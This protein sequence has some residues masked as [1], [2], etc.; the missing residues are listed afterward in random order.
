MK[1]KAI[2]VQDLMDGFKKIDNVL[3]KRSQKLRVR[4]LGG[5]SMLLLGLR[6]R[7]TVD[8]DIAATDDS[9]EFQKLCNKLNIPV[10]IIT[11]ATT[12]DLNHCDMVGVFHGKMLTVDSVTPRDLIKLKLERFYKQDPED[13]YAIIE[14]KSISFDE[15]KNIVTDMIQDYIGNLRQIIISAQ[16]VVELIYPDHVEEFK[17]GVGRM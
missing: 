13:I 6:E 1:F 7:T 8:I 11:I 9:V 15:F 12:V 10:D 17:K 16:I 3:L 2:K 14:S 4:I 5:A